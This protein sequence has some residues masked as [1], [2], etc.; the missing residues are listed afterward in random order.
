MLTGCAAPV[1]QRVSVDAAA[2]A[3]EAKLQQQLALRS[4]AEQQ[5]RL[6]SVGRGVL[7]A[8]GWAVLSMRMASAAGR[9]GEC[10][11]LLSISSRRCTSAKMSA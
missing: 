5:F 11:R 7:A 8:G 10:C 3:N 2:Q 1:T 9:R 6:L 4:M